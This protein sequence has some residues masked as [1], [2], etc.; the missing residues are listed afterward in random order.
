MQNLQNFHQNFFDNQ[1]YNICLLDALDKTK[2]D[3]IKSI[4][5][6]IRESKMSWKCQFVKE[7]QDWKVALGTNYIKIEEKNINELF[8]WF[9]WIKPICLSVGR[10]LIQRDHLLCGKDF[11]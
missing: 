4:S 11:I 5:A 3:K 9:Y 10:L 2:F 7:K 8:W 6:L 1:F